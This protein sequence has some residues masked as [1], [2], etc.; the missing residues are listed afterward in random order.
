M[1]I[2]RMKSRINELGHAQR[3]VII[4]FLLEINVNRMSCGIQGRYLSGC[5]NAD[6]VAIVE[7]TCVGCF[8]ATI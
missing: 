3:L 2:T 7:H 5:S 4:I 1:R 8:V 6:G